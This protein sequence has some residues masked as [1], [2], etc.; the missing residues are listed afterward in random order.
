MRLIIFILTLLLMPISA[1]AQERACLAPKTDTS[2]PPI[3]NNQP[4]EVSLGFFFTDILGVSDPDQNMSADIA[5]IMEWND[6]RLADL[7][8]CLLPLADIWSPRLEMINSSRLTPK[9]TQAR[10]QVQVL[11]NG[12]VR[13]TQRYS[14]TISTYHNLKVFPFDRHVFE[15]EIFAPIFPADQVLITPLEDQTGIA[16]RLNVPDWKF[17]AI[18]ARSATKDLVAFDKPHS[19]LS[20]TLEARRQIF[21]YIFKVMV[22]LALIVSMSWVVFWI[23]P[24][25]FESQ[26]GFGATSMLTLIAFQFSLTSSLP[27]LS[28]FTSMDYLVFG[29]T[30]LV[31]SAILE[32][33]L[34]G[35]LF[36]RGKEYIARRI[37]SFCRILF[38]VLFLLYWIFVMIRSYGFPPST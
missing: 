37:D 21:Y 19:V 31:Y 24:S 3:V 20:I 2:V 9:Y 27:K 25:N 5:Q 17:G 32:A 7:A 28:Y 10:N 14:G 34:T 8:G 30:I 1:M 36:R 22:P 38:P 6:S 18:T 23:P 13:Y 11:D 4:L 15:F 33:L 35:V 26:I 16:K 29:A 12:V